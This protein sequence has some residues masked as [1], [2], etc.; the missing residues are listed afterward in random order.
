[1]FWISELINSRN[2]KFIDP[3]IFPL[4]SS[5]LGSG[6]KPKNL[7]LPRASTNSKFFLSY[8]LDFIWSLFITMFLFSF[9]L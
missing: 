1:M 9:A 6:C 8:I 7:S 5:F 4:L 2:G 3:G